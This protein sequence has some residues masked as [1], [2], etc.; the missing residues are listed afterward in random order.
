MRGG[1]DHRILPPCGAQQQ[2]HQQRQGGLRQQPQQGDPARAGPVFEHVE[3]DDRGIGQ[4]DHG[5]EGGVARAQMV[6][7]GP[8]RSAQGE[9]GADEGQ[10]QDGELQ[11]VE[12][13]GAGFTAADSRNVDL[14]PRGRRIVDPR[15]WLSG[16]RSYAAM[17]NFAYGAP[18]AGMAEGVR[19]DSNRRWRQR[20]QS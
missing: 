20:Q 1:A 18:G 8:Q 6:V 13:H 11:G 17:V 4:G 7:P 5:A 16:A 9:P 2:Q 15:A 10:Q 14:L 12:D 3:D 19:R